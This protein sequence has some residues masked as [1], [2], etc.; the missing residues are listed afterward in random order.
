MTD[1]NPTE[2]FL[3]IFLQDWAEGNLR[4]L[5][6]YLE[7]FPPEMETVIRAALD[8]RPQE[9]EAGVSHAPLVGEAGQQIGPYVIRKELGRGGQGV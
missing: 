7:Q 3:S 4:S 6:S 5:E 9:E 2:R 1:S 8:N